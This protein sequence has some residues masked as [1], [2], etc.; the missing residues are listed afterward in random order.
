MG[1]EKRFRV[2]RETVLWRNSSV[3]LEERFCVCSVGLEER[4]SVSR[5]MVPWV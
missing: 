3:G 4:S 1:L 2:S 5:G